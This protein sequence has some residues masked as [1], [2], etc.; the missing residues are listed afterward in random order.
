MP[1]T[2]FVLGKSLALGLQPIVVINK[3]D[4]PDRRLDV[5]LDA[6]HGP[7][8]RQPSQCIP[9]PGAPGAL[10]Q[11]GRIDQEQPNAASVGAGHRVPVGDA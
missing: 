6:D 4:R 5:V 10:R 2:R 11:L 9:G 3:V 7:E 1:Q 8:R